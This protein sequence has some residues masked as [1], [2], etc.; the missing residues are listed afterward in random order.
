MNLK[1]KKGRRNLVRKQMIHLTSVLKPI[2]FIFI[3]I[4]TPG[5]NEEWDEVSK[6]QKDKASETRVTHLD[7]RRRS[8]P[9]HLLDWPSHPQ[10]PP[11]QPDI[12]K[13]P[14][15][16]AR[17]GN[18]ITGW[19]TISHQHTTSCAYHPKQH[20]FCPHFTPH[21]PLRPSPIPRYLWLAS[22]CCLCLCFTYFFC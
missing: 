5:G 2:K 18:T 3:T 21:A 11:S 8:L 6:N 14:S 16:N 19:L 15:S 20:L 7:L 9:T 13:I 17:M 12:E 4:R 1:K 22:H 10:W